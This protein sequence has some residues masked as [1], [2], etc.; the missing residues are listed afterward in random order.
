ME[1]VGKGTVLQRLHCVI[2]AVGGAFGAIPAHHHFRVVEEVAV[3]G[4]TVLGLPQMHPVRVSVVADFVSLA[5]GQ[6]R[7]LTHSVAPPFP[8]E[9]L[10][11]RG[12]QN[13]GAI[14][15]LQEDNVQHYLRSGVGFEGGVGESDG[16]QKLRSLG[17]I[18]AHGRILGI[19]GIATGDERHHTAGTYLI[20][21]LQYGCHCGS[22]F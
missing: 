14:P 20:Q 3:D 21:L 11:R 1:L 4:I 7:K 10:I 17:K 5:S 13:N 9:S 12:P 19:Q 15:L 6:A 18:P 16:P 2:H 22:P 8:S